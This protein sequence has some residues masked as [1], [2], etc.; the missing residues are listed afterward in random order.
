MYLYVSVCFCLCDIVGGAICYFWE[1]L[2]NLF[3]E[4]KSDN[5]VSSLKRARQFCILIG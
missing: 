1:F 3:E 4:L 2:D 5:L